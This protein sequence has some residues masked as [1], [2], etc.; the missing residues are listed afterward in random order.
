[1]AK[2]P[3]K[4]KD[5]GSFGEQWGSNVVRSAFIDGATFYSKEVQYAEVEGLAIF[6][7]DI[8]LGTVEAV[9]AKTELRR[10][11]LRGEIA[12]GVVITGAQFRWPNCLIPYTIDSS[13]PNQARVTDAIAHWEANTRVRFILRTAAN[14][15]QYPDY[16]TFRPG[17]GCSSW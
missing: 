2:K 5:D 11:E 4:K 8:V 17:S 9:K 7:G 3:Q 10:Q 14:A 15:A 6:E 13:L 12:H 1:M 16:V